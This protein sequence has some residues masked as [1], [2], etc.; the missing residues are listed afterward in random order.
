MKFEFVDIENTG[1]FNGYRED[2]DII[3]MDSNTV[4]LKYRVQITD[5]IES[6]Y[7][8]EFKWSLTERDDLDC[9]YVIVKVK[10]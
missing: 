2:Q 1:L 7:E 9:P 8:N 6:W 5:G 3:K 4:T 10:E